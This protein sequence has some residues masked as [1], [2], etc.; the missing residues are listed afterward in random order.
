MTTTTRTL[1]HYGDD[2]EEGHD[3]GVQ[4]GVLHRGGLP[5]YVGGSGGASASGT[6]AS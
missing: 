2:Q 3:E 6:G 4:E 1:A 5:L